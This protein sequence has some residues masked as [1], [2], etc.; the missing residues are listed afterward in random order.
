MSRQ[1]RTT[2]LAIVAVAIL[3]A[4]CGSPTA[5]P[6][7][8]PIPVLTITCP[9]AT[10]VQSSD[11]QPVPVSFGTATSSGGVAPV[12]TACATE[13]GSTFPPGA[14]PVSCSAQDARG[15]SAL[16]SF[17][18]TVQG[19]PRLVG[20]RLLAFGDSL[21]WGTDSPPLR[22]ASPSFAYPEQ[23]QRKLVQYYRVQAPVVIN[24]G[25]PGEYAQDTGV[26]RIRRV[27]QQ[28]RPDI[29]L[30][31]EGTNDL[32]LAEPVGA[33]RAMEALRTM[34]RTAK[35]LGIRVGIATIPPQRAGGA[36]NR[37]RVAGLIPGFND[38]IRALAAA[39]NIVVIDVYNAMKDDISLIGEDDLH[40]TIRGFDVM[41]NVFFEGV[42]AG[43]EEKF[44]A[45]AAGAR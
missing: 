44:T 29:L 43:F 36:R 8:P 6:P 34:I 39:E 20:T 31:M 3:S 26:A 11:G 14:T 30:L 18:V 12:S 10:T 21:T 27:L 23:L 1:K 19:P 45:R 38:R 35:D 16:C 24:E 13:S 22:A 17:T 7:P 40:P 4:R 33:D 15:V 2:A 42:K 25:V 32:L 28:H 37:G 41:A 9:E 5:P